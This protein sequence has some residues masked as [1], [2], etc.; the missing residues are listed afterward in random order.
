MHI[1]EVFLMNILLRY[2]II[3]T[4][5]KCNWLNVSCFMNN[6]FTSSVLNIMLAPI[7]LLLNGSL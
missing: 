2:P 5:I 3:R 7:I 4:S 1:S 6:K